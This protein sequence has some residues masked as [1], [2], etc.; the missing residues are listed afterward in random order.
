M[1]SDAMDHIGRGKVQFSKKEKR[2]YAIQKARE[3]EI[4]DT[5]AV[6]PDWMTDRALLPKRP[7]RRNP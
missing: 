2:A 5:G 7:P 3:E 4:K 1:G 6:K